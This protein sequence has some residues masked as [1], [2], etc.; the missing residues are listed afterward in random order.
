MRNYYLD[1]VLGRYRFSNHVESMLDWDNITSIFLDMDGT[2]LDL[3]YDNYFWL[4]YVP[5]R[6]SRKYDLPIEETK[7]IL[8]SRYKSIEGTLEWYCVDYWSRELGLDITAL[9][10]EIAD[11]IE[12]HPHVETFLTAAKKAN[13]RLVLVT[14]AHGSS[15]DL[16]LSKTGL[17][18]YFDRIVISHDVGEPKENHRFW[19][20]LRDQEP[21]EPS[22]SLLVDD[23]L[24]VLRCA[25][26]YGIENLLAIKRPDTQAAPKDTGEFRGIQNFEEIL[27]INEAPK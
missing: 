10:H 2:L 14:N 6:Y 21:H 24:S 7:Q 27:P 20:L 25:A 15:V 11:K 8:Y 16:K 13:K 3:H 4:D 22:K 23:N 1:R 18:A 17:R 26:D 5:D 9:K 12:I 19:P